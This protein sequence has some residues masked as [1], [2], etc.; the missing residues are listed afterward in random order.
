M[1]RR[2]GRALLYSAGLGLGGGLGYSLHQ[3]EGDIS[4]IGAVRS[5][6]I[7]Y[8]VMGDKE[9]FGSVWSLLCHFVCLSLCFGLKL[10]ISL[11][12]NLHLIVFVGLSQVS[13]SSHQELK[14]GG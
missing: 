8:N 2:L 10:S 14:Q 5:G 7:V 6:Y 11:C 12:L 4:N 3:S 9:V 13:V 1:A